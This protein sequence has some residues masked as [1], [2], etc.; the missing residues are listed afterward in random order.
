MTATT[1]ITLSY[2]LGLL[3]LAVDIWRAR[4]LRADARQRIEEASEAA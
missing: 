2:L 1:A 3:V 4:A